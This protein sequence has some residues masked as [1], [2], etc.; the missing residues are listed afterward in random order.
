VGNTPNISG[1]VSDQRF[2]GLSPG[3][4]RTALAR[5]TGDDRFN[6]LDDGETYQLIQRLAPEATQ[7]SQLPNPALQAK[8]RLLSRQPGL[9]KDA[10]L[11]PRTLSEGQDDTRQQLQSMLAGVTGVPDVGR[12]TPSQA[13]TGAATGALAGGAMLSPVVT[14]LGLLG[15]QA[16]GEV[17]GGVSKLTGASPEKQEMWRT[18]G[19]L[20]GGLVGGEAGAALYPGSV[21]DAIGNPR[22]WW[23]QRTGYTPALEQAKRVNAANYFRSEQEGQ[24]AVA[25]REQDIAK[26]IFRNTEKANRQQLQAGEA[27]STAQENLRNVMAEHPQ[28]E[29]LEWAR[30]NQ[31]IEA[32]TKGMQV[33]KGATLEE[34][35]RNAGRGLAR[36]GYT[37][38]K[39]LN[40]TPVE[41]D[42][43][44]T[45]SWN[46]AGRAVS[47]AGE[48]ATKAGVTID[49]SKSASEVLGRS[50]RP[51]LA[52][53]AAEAFDDLAKDLGI[54]NIQ[55]VTP[56]QAIAFRKALKGSR[57]GAAGDLGT[58]KGI[59]RDL[60][61]GISRDLHAAVPGLSELDAH[62][63]DLAA[64][65]D[66]T[67]INKG[68]YAAG[69]W[70]RPTLR[71][72]NAIAD[73]QKAMQ[74]STWTGGETLPT[75][76]EMPKA[77]PYTPLPKASDYTYAALKRAAK[78]GVNALGY[79]ALLR[80]LARQ[81]H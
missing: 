53:T 72:E 70:K 32:P 52:S 48:D 26:A 19:Q 4:K 55:K 51:D 40:V 46:A 69:T 13:K 81:Q 18:T 28:G 64:A 56:T 73:V 39:L 60:S 54:K 11:Y 67:R 45:D 9:T 29:P 36:E 6:Q 71:I 24:E 15:S 35:Q 1:L 16:G 2:Q 68:K 79:E 57:F 49:L 78:L 42:R 20:S 21:F 33:A 12:V 76:V 14:A 5:V 27:L 8:Q 37:P 74:P 44:A 43:A 31:A 10:G 34:L 41:V 65:T 59:D 30:I 63:A 58:I 22:T 7:I 17:T 62:Y 77:S 75:P 23:N 50:P 25:G 3:D 80:I 66:I 61:R 38:E 47:K